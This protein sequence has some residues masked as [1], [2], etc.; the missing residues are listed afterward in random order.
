MITVEYT[1][2]LFDTTTSDDITDRVQGFS[3]SVV[4]PYGATGSAEAT[5]TLTNYDGAFT[6]GA[7]GTYSDVDYFAKA[8]LIDAMTYEDGVAVSAY[9]S[10]IFHG[11]ITGFELQDNGVTSTVELVCDDFLTVGGRSR[12]TT[13]TLSTGTDVGIARFVY[14]G[15]TT[16]SSLPLLAAD[17]YLLTVIRLNSST[18]VPANYR[19]G[20]GPEGNAAQVLDTE[21][22]PSGPF[23]YWPYQIKEDV[24]GGEASYSAG[25]LNPYLN[26]DVNTSEFEYRQYTFT[27][28]ESPSSAGDMPYLI[29][30][31]GWTIDLLKNRASITKQNAGIETPVQQTAVATESVNKYGESSVVVGSTVHEYNADALVAA[32]RWANRFDTPRFVPRV[33][34]TSTRLLQSAPSG[35]GESVHWALSSLRSLWNRFDITFTPTGAVSSQT[36]RC[37]AMSRRIDATPGDTTITYELLPYEDVTSF[38]LDSDTLGVLDTNRLG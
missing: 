38:V 14:A 37:V 7:G 24:F 23:V 16:Q 29:V 25:G 33:L 31:R 35:T 28:T 19:A 2:T 27:W 15:A 13:P 36:D 1:I 6:P 22:M 18:V 20:T 12:V 3:C 8:I 10:T 26:R 9:T 4:A 30:E 34:Q 17:D 5:L 21:I 32:E 11:L